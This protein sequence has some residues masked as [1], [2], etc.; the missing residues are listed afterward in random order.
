MSW[1]LLVKKAA[2]GHLLTERQAKKMRR[3]VRQ[4]LERTRS[5]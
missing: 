2:Q 1:W 4:R 5:D 3:A